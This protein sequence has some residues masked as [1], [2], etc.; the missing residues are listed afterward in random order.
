MTGRTSETQQRRSNG[1]ADTTL[2]DARQRWRRPWVTIKTEAIKVEPKF[3]KVA[4]ALASASGHRIQSLDYSKGPYRRQV[5]KERFC[6]LGFMKS[7]AEYRTWHPAHAPRTELSRIVSDSTATYRMTRRSSLQE[8]VQL[9]QGSD[10]WFQ[11]TKTPM[12]V[13]FLQ[14]ESADR[15]GDGLSFLAVKLDL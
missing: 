7:S 3:S 11:S 10:G 4:D 2:C 5:E 15:R 9:G 1:P 14:D 6:S 12:L 13:L 8:E